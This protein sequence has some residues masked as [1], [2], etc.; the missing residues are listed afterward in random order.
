MRRTIAVPQKPCRCG[1]CLL[2]SEIVVKHG[3]SRRRTERR[4]HIESMTIVWLRGVP[5]RCDAG[6][7][8]RQQ[9]KLPRP[10]RSN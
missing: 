8:G 4:R 5:V 9:W 2:A 7:V 1:M 10:M 3:D 6:V